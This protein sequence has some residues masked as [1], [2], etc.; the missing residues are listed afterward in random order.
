M[1]ENE[2]HNN[3]QAPTTGEAEHKNTNQPRV[4][5]NSDR[6]KQ[7]PSPE[8][9]NEPAPS[10]EEQT[11][12]QDQ[13]TSQTEKDTSEDK[14]ANEPTGKS[15]DETKDRAASAEE[16]PKK[17]AE[18]TSTDKTENDQAKHQSEEGY[19][20]EM[21]EYGAM[22]LAALT[23]EFQRL[24]KNHKVQDV[25]DHVRELK[26]NFDAKFG[27]EIAEKKEA[28]LADGGSII[29]FHYST[30]V[31]KDFDKTYFEYR[32]KRDKYYSD[33]KQ[34]LNKNLEE[35]LSII[36]DLKNMIGGSG[37][38]KANFKDFKFLQ[39][40]WKKAGPVPRDRYKKVADTYHHHVQNFY[41]FLHLDREFRDMDFKHNLEQKLKM[42]SRAQELAEEKNINRAFR[43]L[44]MLHKMWKEDVGP[45]A[46]EYREPIWDKFSAATKQIHQ[47]R[48]AHFA[49]LDKKREENLA[50]KRDLIDKI[51]EIEAKH[52]N[53]HNQAQQE[54]KKV[55]K[56]RDDFFKAG[57]VP[58]KHNKEV[59]ND[60]KEVTRD[61]KH[62]KNEFYKTLKNELKENLSKKR[63]LLEVAEENKDSE[64]FDTVTPLMKKIQS[65]WKTIGRVPRKHSDKIWKAFQGA[66]NHYFERLHALQDEE[67]QEEREA[68]EEKKELL[69]NT[70]SIELE[71]D[72]E[73]DLAVIK[74]QIAAW[75]ELG[76]VPR[77]KRFIEKK[78]N[79]A[80]DQL[81]GQLDI[82]KKQVEMMKYEKKV[83]SLDESDDERQIEKEEGFLRKKIG[84]TE[85]EIRQLEANLGMFSNADEN[86][87]L[88]KEA[89][90]NINRHKEQLETWKAK[91]KKVRE[92]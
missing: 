57:K 3:D 6:E 45:V 63:E 35:R 18:E 31:K 5:Q 73:K 78:F 68:F 60:F 86:N 76:T 62:K 13:N 92:L 38:M 29:D 34:N 37:S 65:E 19:A 75:K 46:K 48:R 77:K 42:I 88:M 30:P 51:Q 4:D 12:A 49:E 43:E 40:R 82:D 90:K 32:E 26:M 23:E 15:S 24:L 2:N 27:K 84:E 79:K 10:Q 16:P 14:K 70:K 22:N 36:E 64:D 11:E 66:C 47:N 20:I 41:D 52:I 54:I 21:K 1:Q 72:H 71:G 81:F 8:E 44:Q 85:S 80:L 83:Q 56:L 58:K 7:E 33:L 9:V 67:K 61:F 89:Y 17:T 91:L 59:W 69:E 55:N 50:V 25:R 39:E 87:P 53:S 74:K 28:F